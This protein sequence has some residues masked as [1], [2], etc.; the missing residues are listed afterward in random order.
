MASPSP[1]GENCYAGE[2]SDHQVLYTS[3]LDLEG[4]VVDIA[5]DMV[6]DKST[7][8]EEVLSV[9]DP[10]LKFVFCSVRKAKIQ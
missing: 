5:F 3:A 7:M 6:H 4:Y 2:S 1:A 9:A 8:S 10:P